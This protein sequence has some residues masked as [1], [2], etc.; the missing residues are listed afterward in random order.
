M[1]RVW[2]KLKTL[3]SVVFALSLL[4]SGNLEQL[5][6]APKAPES[7]SESSAFDPLKLLS[8]TSLAEESVTHTVKV[9]E[10]QEP[11]SGDSLPLDDPNSSLGAAVVQDWTRGEVNF[12]WELIGYNEI[13]IHW[14]AMTVP[15]P[16][17]QSQ[18][19]PAEGVDHYELKWQNGETWETLKETKDD[20][21]FLHTGLPEAGKSTTFL[22]SGAT[23]HRSERLILFG[24]ELSLYDETISA[25]G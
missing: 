7:E 14:D 1:A 15:D 16:Q 11:Q 21:Y 6:A 24:P 5:S 2:R 17:N 18:R 23:N 25:D 13:E 19:V 10:L 22:F 8:S 3:A 20:F 4:L 12:R 9:A